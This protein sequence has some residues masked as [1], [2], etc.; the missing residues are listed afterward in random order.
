MDASPSLLGRERELSDLCDLI[1]AQRL[2]TIT[3][4]GGVG[5]TRLALAMAERAAHPVVCPLA[6]YS[7][8]EQVPAAVAESLGFPSWDAALAGLADRSA[9]LVLDNC[10]HLL[11]AVADAVELLSAAG[12]VSVLATSREPLAVPGEHVMRLEPLAVGDGEGPSDAAASPAVQL[13]LARAAAAGSAVELD[14]DAAPT[15]VELCRRLDGLPLAIELAAA[16]T[17]TLT[18]AE[19]LGHL[20]RRLDLLV[21][22]RRGPP[23]HRSLET[24]VDWSY[25][26]LDPRTRRFFD[27]LGVSEGRFTAEAALAVAGEPGEDLLAVIGHLDQLVARSLVQVHRRGGRTWYGLLETIRAYARAKVIASGEFD[28]VTNRCIDWTVRHCREIT[29]RSWRSWSAELAATADALRH[30]V[31]DA[32]GRVVEHDE[33]PGRAF[34]LYGLLLG[35]DVHNGRA[36]PVAEWGERLLARWPDPAEPGWSEVAAVAATA[37]VVAGDRVRGPEL[38][39]LALDAAGSPPAALIARRALLLVS[40]AGPSDGT[41]IR[42]AEDALSHARGQDVRPWRIELDTFRAIALADAGRDAGAL[43]AAR[44]AHAE[45]AATDGPVLAAWCAL[46]HGHVLALHD[47]D[48]ARP[49]FAEVLERSSAADYPLGRGLGHRALGALDLLAGCP[50]PAAAAFRTAL[51]ELVRVGDAHVRTTLRWIAV[52]ARAAG[53]GTA[54][55]RLSAAASASPA[56]DLSDLL[57]Q[58]TLGRHL[59]VVAGDGP[60]PT[61][62]DAIALARQVLAAIAEQADRPGPEA[63]PAASAF[64][65]EGPVWHLAFDGD[66]VRLPDAKGFHDLAALLAKPGREIHAAELMGMAVEA[67]DTGPA[68]DAQ[69]RRSYES[70]IVELQAE[71]VE[72]EDAHDRGAAERARLEMDL[73]VEHLTAATGLGGRPRRAGGNHERA[74]SAVGWRIRA[75]ITRIGDAHPSLGRHLRATVR[76]GTWCSYQPESPIQWDL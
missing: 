43:T 72:A 15:L 11:D 67:P 35:A 6:R 28:A 23:R 45:A 59:A 51:D 65:R 38:A 68:L 44:D 36:R 42:L 52:L 47:A 27:R 57:A 58:A 16:R 71:L 70:R 7:R 39:R 50:G 60:A 46:V 17:P 5:K 49:V 37:H 22:N 62:R 48:A 56:A 12:D 20:D 8:P 26:R 1:S 2:V 3:G 76:T 40:L 19:I 29:E 31:Y 34:A 55:T 30:D 73:L 63:S 75:A 74:R 54:A 10:E 53:H 33:R 9:L 13:F 21:G 41:A 4:V 69:A 32:L 18:P 64:R 61:V 66:A 25:E 14:A 24:M